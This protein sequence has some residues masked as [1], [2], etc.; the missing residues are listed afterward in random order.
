[1]QVQPLSLVAHLLFV[2]ISSFW[3]LFSSLLK[4]CTFA[5]NI[6]YLGAWLLQEPFGL[7]FGW[8]LLLGLGRI[9]FVRDPSG[10]LV[11]GLGG[12]GLL[13]IIGR[14]WSLLV[15]IGASCLFL[16]LWFLHFK[17]SS[18]PYLNIALLLITFAIWELGSYRTLWASLRSLGGLIC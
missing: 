17:S 7:L 6:C 1:M 15:V 16:D 4:Y 13:G 14:S 12:L 10:T 2:L 9:G 5:Y 8:S 3:I 11:L 18:A